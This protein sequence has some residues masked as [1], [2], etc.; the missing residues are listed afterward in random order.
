MSKVRFIYRIEYHNTKTGARGRFHC[1]DINSAFDY[2]DKTN[3]CYANVYEFE[4]IRVLDK[5]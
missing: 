2:M 5:Y 3:N 4:V 1:R